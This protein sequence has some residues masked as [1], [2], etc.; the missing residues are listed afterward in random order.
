MNNALLSKGW[1][2]KPFEK[3]YTYSNNRNTKNTIEI[4]YIPLITTAA[5]VEPIMANPVAH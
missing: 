4:L 2:F 3:Y 1:N 5:F